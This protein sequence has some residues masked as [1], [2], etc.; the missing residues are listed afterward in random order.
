VSA[1]T[2][3]VDDA[4]QAYLSQP[5]NFGSDSDAQRTAESDAFRAGVV[6]ALGHTDWRVLAGMIPG[7]V[8]VRH[9]RDGDRLLFSGV[10]VE[11]L[12]VERGLYGALHVKT[13]TDRGGQIVLERSPIERVRVLSTGAMVQ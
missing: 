4:V 13:Q 9:V 5:L 1:L 12:G 6:W 3:G 7:P 11:V 2:A 8:E 10:E